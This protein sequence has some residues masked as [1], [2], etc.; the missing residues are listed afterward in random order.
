MLEIIA[1]EQPNL[2][3]GYAYTTVIMPHLLLEVLDTIIPIDYSDFIH[4]LHT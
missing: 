4:S 3:A 2:L 1:A